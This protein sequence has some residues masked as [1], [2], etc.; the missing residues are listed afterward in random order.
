MPVS[1]QQLRDEIEVLR[2]QISAD[3]QAVVAINMRLSEKQGE[4]FWP[5]YREYHLEKDV[6]MDRRVKILT[7]FSENYMGMTFDQAENIL[8]DA[9]KLEKSLLKLKTSYRK[10]FQKVL[11][12]RGALRYYQIENKLDTIINFNIASV[13]PLR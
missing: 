11:S 8:I 7:E 13:V 9:L 2:G 5:L 4:K 12:S 3:R 6:L 1:A 10:K